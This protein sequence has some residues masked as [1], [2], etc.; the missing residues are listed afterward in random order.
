MG[1][2]EYA[3]TSGNDEREANIQKLDEIEGIGRKTAEALHEI[4]IR[5]EN[6]AQYLRQHTT[7]EISDELRKHGFRPGPI[8]KKKWLRSLSSKQEEYAPASLI[9]EEIE[10]VK[11][12]KETRSSQNMHN[13]DIEFTVLF[14]VVKNKNGKPV[15]QVTIYDPRDA[16]EEKQFEGN[17]PAPWVN[18][19]LE[20]SDLT[21][22]PETIASPPEAVVLP[23]FAKPFDAQ[24]EIDNAQMSVV[25][26]SPEIP[27]KS[28]R[29]AISFRLSGV[30][31]E[32]LASQGVPIQIEIYTIDLDKGVPGLVGSLESR[33][34]PNQFEYTYQ[35][36]F[37]IP[38]VG[39]YAFHSVVKLLPI[40]NLLADHWGPTMKVIP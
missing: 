34:E 25:G 20:R 10:S 23:I 28:L 27:K 30:D 35:L 26:P 2:H 29:A 1:T 19:M 8:N 18:W 11:E 24:L 5:Y 39:S 21:L 38:D 40:G 9:S 7:K 17:D 14:D 12:S 36:E 31:V 3:T 22:A 4:G 37:A 33:L 16:G 13:E 6:F 15:L 32:G